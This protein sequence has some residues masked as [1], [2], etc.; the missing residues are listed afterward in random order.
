MDESPPPPEFAAYPEAGR[1]VSLAAR[2]GL[3]DTR[4]DARV[5][6]DALARFLQDVADEDA[7]TAPV[8]DDESM[9]VLR[10]LVV[11]LTRTPRF[12]DTL[13]L[14]TWCSGTGARWAERRT[15]VRRNGAADVAVRGVG[16]WVHVDRER[17]RPSSLPSSFNSVWGVSAG[18]RRVR[19]RL[20]HGAPDANSTRERWPLRATD[21][22]VVGHVNN[23][24][25]WAAIEELLARRPTMRVERAEIEF[26][27]GVLP[28]EDVDLVVADERDGFRCW[29][30]VGPE[31][32]ASVLVGSRR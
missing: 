16:L 5:R 25:Y 23:A 19:A 1:V 27:A 18:N 7:A 10:R 30:L 2:V 26:R 13:D 11:D 31:V 24:A 14:V 21:I 12:R 32:R 20:E 28:G 8:D 4:R 15:D 3:G 17:G 6:L 22:D 29:F 9:W